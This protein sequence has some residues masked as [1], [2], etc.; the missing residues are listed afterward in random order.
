MKILDNHM[1]I[2]IEYK[3]YLR[4]IKHKTEFKSYILKSK[5][6]N[7]KIRLKTYRN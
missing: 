5:T 7:L 2:K 6:K 3:S 1:E 4:L